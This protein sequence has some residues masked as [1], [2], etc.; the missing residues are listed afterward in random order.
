MLPFKYTLIRKPRRRTLTITVSRDNK[1]IVRSPLALPQEEIRRFLKQKE[2]WI[3]KTILFNRRT[4]KPYIPKSFTAGEKFF[5]LGQEYPLVIEEKK[6]KKEIRLENGTFYLYLPARCNHPNRYIARK[7][8]HWYKTSAYRKLLEV[9]CAYERR[10]K[11]TISDLR[12]KTLK[13]TWGSCSKKG[14]VTFSWKLILAPLYILEYV[15]VHE[16]CHLIHHNHSPRFW[17]E[18][19]KLIPDYKQRKK[20]LAVNENTVKL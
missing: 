15:V 10:L 4:R 3:N 8:I 6:E 14:I 17:Q 12:I 20:W 18:V 16:L 13:R 2:K 9:I 19:G 7:F 11:V 1:I 5:Y